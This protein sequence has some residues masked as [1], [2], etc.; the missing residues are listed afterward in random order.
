[1]TNKTTTVVVL[2][3]VASGIIGW[4]SG[5]FSRLGSAMS[6]DLKVRGS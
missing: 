4:K 3:A 6:G 1:M 2:M 5:L